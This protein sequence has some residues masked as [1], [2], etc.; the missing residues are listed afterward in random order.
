MAQILT[1]V[2]TNRGRELFAK[3]LGSLGGFDLVQ[4]VKFRYG[5]GGFIEV[6][7]GGKIPK[8]PDPTLLNVEAPTWNPA[9]LFSFEKPLTPSDFNF[10]APFTIEIRC[11]LNPSEAN[12]NLSLLSPKFFELGIFDGNSNMLAYATFDEQTKTATKSLIS[13]VQ[14]FF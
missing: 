4:A 11:R 8:E 12:L 5:E 14:I 9:P 10:I 13:F 1:G 6:P 7:G 3:S 2:V